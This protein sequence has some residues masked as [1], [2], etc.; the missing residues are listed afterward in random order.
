MTTAIPRRWRFRVNRDSRVG[1]FDVRTLTP[2]GLQTPEPRQPPIALT[3]A[4][5]DCSSGAGLTA[6]LRAF[7]REGAYGLSVATAIVAQSPGNLVAIQHAEFALVEAQLNEVARYPLD[8]AKTGMLA[9]QKSAQLVAEWFD[10]RISLPLVVDP[11]LRATAGDIP[12]IEAPS[13]PIYRDSLFPRATLAT[14]NSNE[15]ESLLGFPVS[16]PEDLLLASR[17]F[18]N[19]FGCSALIKGGHL[20]SGPDD[21][22]LDAFCERGQAELWESPRLPVPDLH[23]TGC[24]LSAAITAGLAAGLPLREAVLKARKRLH[25]WMV[26]YHCWSAGVRSM[27]AL[28]AIPRRPEPES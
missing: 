14:P 4:G 2:E 9:S 27:E 5:F 19:R 21:A 1:R 22:V 11:V 26:E 12:L 24:T 18:H 13:I 20:R 17:E 15:A 28:N 10:E 7:E 16:T 8:A 23:G 25:Q 3:I 6:D